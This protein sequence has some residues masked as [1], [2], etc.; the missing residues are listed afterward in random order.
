M[1]IL[2][3]SNAL[4]SASLSFKLFI[5]ILTTFDTSDLLFRIISQ[6]GVAFK[7]IFYKKAHNFVFL[8]F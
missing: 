1:Y 8:V 3:S 7:S 4:Y 2:C 6:P 5:F